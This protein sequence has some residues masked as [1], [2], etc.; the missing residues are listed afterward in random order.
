MIEI[1][2][3]LDGGALLLLKKKKKSNNF[4]RRTKKPGGSVQTSPV[5]AAS[6]LVVHKHDHLFKCNYIILSEEISLE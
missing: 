1:V 3:E 5:R 6:V 2:T 4:R